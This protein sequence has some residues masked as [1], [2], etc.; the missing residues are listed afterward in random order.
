MPNCPNVPT[1][2]NC[3]DPHHW[4]CAHCGRSWENHHSWCPDRDGP[5]VG[6]DNEGRPTDTSDMSMF[7]VYSK[8]ADHCGRWALCA[9]RVTLEK[10]RWREPLIYFPTWASAKVIFDQVGGEAKGFWMQP[11]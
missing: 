3:L 4:H 10:G 7:W 6:K 8:A 11:A 9:E 1:L 2:A 5:K